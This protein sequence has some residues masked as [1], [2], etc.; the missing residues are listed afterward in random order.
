MRPLEREAK[1]PLIVIT[2]VRPIVVSHAKNPKTIESELGPIF[3]FNWN[4]Q[5]TIKV[6]SGVVNDLLH[7]VKGTSLSKENHHH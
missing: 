5:L 3:G 1:E 6:G 2:K 7:C 4:R